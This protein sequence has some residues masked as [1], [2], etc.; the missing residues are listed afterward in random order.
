MAKEK[1]EVQEEEI[2]WEDTEAAIFCRETG[3]DKMPGLYHALQRAYTGSSVVPPRTLD[4]SLEQLAEMAVGIRTM[5]NIN[6]IAQRGIA[7]A[8][9]TKAGYLKEA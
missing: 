1:V 9:L 6:L 3:L 5:F 7:R 4:G 2:A 8:L